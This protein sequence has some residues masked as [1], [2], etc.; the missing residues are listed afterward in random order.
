MTKRAL[1]I[2]LPEEIDRRLQKVA[3]RTKRPKPACALEILE[4]YLSDYED[5]CL[6]L[7]RLNVSQARYYS[8]KEAE[9][10]LGL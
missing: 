3:V 7:K 4:H 1:V 2:Q 10:L 9:K 6:A 8:T 5:A